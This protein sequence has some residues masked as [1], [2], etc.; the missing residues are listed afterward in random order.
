M[1]H[2]HPADIRITDQHG[3]ILERVEWWFD[4]PVEIAEF[5]CSVVID[6]YNRYKQPIERRVMAG[7]NMVLSIFRSNS[8]IKE[9]T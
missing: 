6:F 7:K 5:R 2:R 3:T 9:Q 4:D 8:L 1:S